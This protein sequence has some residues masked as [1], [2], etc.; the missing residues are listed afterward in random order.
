MIKFIFNDGAN[1]VD[2]SR[3]VT[4]I[5]EVIDPTIQIYQYL[6]GVTVDIDQVAAA[7]QTVNFTLTLNSSTFEDFDRGDVLEAVTQIKKWA[8]R[9]AKLSGNILGLTDETTKYVITRADTTWIR[10]SKNQTAVEITGTIIR[11]QS[12]ETQSISSDT[13]IRRFRVIR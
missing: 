2:L 5:S 1:T 13:P 9:A 12:D 6:D 8:A 11:I 4:S 10:D 7:T 3:W